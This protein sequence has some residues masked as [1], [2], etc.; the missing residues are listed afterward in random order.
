MRRGTAVL[1]RTP[2]RSRGAALGTRVRSVSGRG[3]LVREVDALLTEYVRLSVGKCQWCGHAR[4][5]LEASHY[6]RRGLWG[7]RY[8]LDNVV[9]AHRRC[10]EFLETRKAPGQAYCSLMVSLLGVNG[11]HALAFRAAQHVKPTREWLLGHRDRLRRL[12]AREG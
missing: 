7:T 2:L 8:D 4:G 6:F 1:R 12:V 3:R 11:L 9:A 5:P 10:H